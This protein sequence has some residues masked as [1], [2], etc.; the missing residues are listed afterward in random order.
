MARPRSDVQAAK[1]KTASGLPFLKASSRYYSI[2]KDGQRKYRGWDKETAIERY[3]A[4]LKLWPLRE[5]GFVQ[6]RDRGPGGW[7]A[8]EVSLEPLE[9]QEILEQ[10]R[11]A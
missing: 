7:L 6:W 9:P 5:N 4:S 11:F 10:E 1:G 2:D 8:E 3:R